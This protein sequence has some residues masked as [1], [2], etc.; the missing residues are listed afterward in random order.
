[1]RSVQSQTPH[2]EQQVMS[3]HLGWFA[4]SIA[5]AASAF[6]CAD[7][8]S[9][10]ES[11]PLVLLDEHEQTLLPRE[12]SYETDLEGT[13]DPVDVTP[14]VLGEPG[15]VSSGADVMFDREETRPC[16]FQERADASARCPGDRLLG[17]CVVHYEVWADDSEHTTLT[18]AH[19]EIPYEAPT[20][21]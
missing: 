18:E 1:M 19:C 5:L 14:P 4:G 17:R 13:L 9:T 11:A 3:I 7:T 12:G 6:G 16:T 10:A 20:Q 8:S 21:S 2:G 15:L